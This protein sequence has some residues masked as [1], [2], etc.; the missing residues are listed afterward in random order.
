MDIVCPALKNGNNDQDLVS[1]WATG[2]MGFDFDTEFAAGG[3]T[4]VNA[5]YQAPSGKCSDMK[6]S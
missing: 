4:L 5:A 6:A 1:H 3:L 2:I